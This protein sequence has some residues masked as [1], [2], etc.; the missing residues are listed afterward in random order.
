MVK[1]QMK[2][3]MQNLR[4]KI[5]N[6]GAPTGSIYGRPSN[7]LVGKV[8]EGTRSHNNWFIQTGSIFNT[9]AFSYLSNTSKNL[10]NKL[11][12]KQCITYI[13]LQEKNMRIKKIKET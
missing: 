2:H 13:Q 9:P 4:G 5:L 1:L 3:V 6:L 7:S 8:V 12:K 10:H 11:S